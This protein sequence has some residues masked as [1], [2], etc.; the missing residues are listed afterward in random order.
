MFRN[1]SGGVLHLATTLGGPSGETHC[2]QAGCSLEYVLSYS[3]ELAC[4]FVTHAG[5]FRFTADLPAGVSEMN[6]RLVQEAEAGE[7][8]LG[9]QVSTATR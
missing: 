3:L 9:S 1:E 4:S 8:P 5:M 6:E 7:L 2:Y